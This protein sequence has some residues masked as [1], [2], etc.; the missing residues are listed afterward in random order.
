[1]LFLWNDY[2]ERRMSVRMKP[3]GTWTTQVRCR[4]YNGDS[5]HK[6]KRDC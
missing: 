2:E 3:N 1:M 4:D 5:R 6:I